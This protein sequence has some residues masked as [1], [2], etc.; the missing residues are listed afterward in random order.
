M[1]FVYEFEDG[2]IYKLADIGFCLRDIWALEKIH[3]KL[4]KQSRK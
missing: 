2:W 1:I 4:I 3:G